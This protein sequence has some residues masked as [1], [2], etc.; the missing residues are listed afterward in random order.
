MDSWLPES[1]DKNQN[2]LANRHYGRAE[3]RRFEVRVYRKLMRRGSR[4]TALPDAEAELPSPP[5]RGRRTEKCIRHRASESVGPRKSATITSSAGRGR[6]EVDR[7]RVFRIYPQCAHLRGRIK[8]RPRLPHLADAVGPINPIQRDGNA[9]PNAP[10]RQSR[11]PVCGRP[12]GSLTCGPKTRF[13]RGRR[14][15]TRSA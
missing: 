12:C 4:R 1:R 11:V 8:A 9:Q 10:C 5:L 13:V 14:V 3:L 2:C 7:L 15:R 6:R